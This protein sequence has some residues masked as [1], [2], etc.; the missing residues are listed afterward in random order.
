MATQTMFASGLII[1]LVCETCEEKPCPHRNW[2]EKNSC[3][4]IVDYNEKL[5]KCCATCL[6]LAADKYCSK[7]ADG[8]KITP[9]TNFRRFLIDDIFHRTCDKWGNT[10]EEE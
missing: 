8:K 9:R 7:M 6:H 3:P 2:L 5:G 1:N 4:R 10:Y